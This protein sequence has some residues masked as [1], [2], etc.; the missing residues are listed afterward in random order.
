MSE[1]L[2]VGKADHSAPIFDQHIAKVHMFLT[3]PL[4]G[5]QIVIGEQVMLFAHYLLPGMP[6]DIIYPLEDLK[7]MGHDFLSLAR[8]SFRQDKRTVQGWDGHE[9]GYT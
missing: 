6:G 1:N 5:L 7:I 4:N 3:G 8:L 9:K 2:K